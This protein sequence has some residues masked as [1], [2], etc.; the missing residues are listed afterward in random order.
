MNRFL[1]ALALYLLAATGAAAQTNV[2]WGANRGANPWTVCLYDANQVCQPVLTLPATGGAANNF[3]GV[4][5]GLTVTPTT[6][7]LTI[8]NGKTLTDTSGV[9]AKLLL[10]STGGGFTGY[11]GASSAGNVLT[12]IGAN[13][14]GSFQP[15]GT[16]GNSTLVETS[17]AGLVSPSILPF[18]TAANQVAQGGVI[19]AG[20]PIGSATVAPIITYNAAGQLTTVS[21]AT[22]TPAVGS[23]TGLGSNVGTALGNTLNA[24]GGLVGYSGALG[25]PTSGTL[26]NATGLPAA[27]GIA[28]GALPAGVTVNNGN[29]SGTGLALTNIATIA[30][31]SIV[32]NNTGSTGG[33]Y[34]LTGAQAAGVLN[35]TGQTLFAGSFSRTASAPCDLLS[36]GCASAWSVTRK[37]RAGYG[38]N[39]FQVTRASDNATQAIGI[40]SLGAVDTTTLVNFCLSTTCAVSII[41][42][43]AGSNNLTQATAANMPLV[44]IGDGQALPYVQTSTS[45]GTG[46]YSNVNTYMDNLSTSGLPTGAAAKTINIVQKGGYSACCGGFGLMENPVPSDGGAAE[47][48]QMF[49][50]VFLEQFGLWYF[51]ADVEQGY[52]YGAAVPALGNLYGTIKLDGSTGKVTALLNGATVA[53]AIWSPYPVNAGSRIALGSAGDKTPV[54]LSFYEGLIAAEFTSAA[55]DAAVY[56]NQVAFYNG[57][58]AGLPSQIAANC[59]MITCEVLSGGLTDVGTLWQNTSVG[60]HAW[61]TQSSGSGTGALGGVGGFTIR[62]TTSGAD[63]FAIKADGL[64][65]VGG[66]LKTNAWFTNVATT[67]DETACGKVVEFTGAGG[68]TL[69]IPSA[70]GLA[71]CTISLWSTGNNTTLS[72][73]SN[74]DGAWGTSSTSMTLTAGSTLDIKSDGYN[75]FTASSSMPLSTTASSASVGGLSSVQA[76]TGSGAVGGYGRFVVIYGSA[77]SVAL[78]TPVGSFGYVPHVIVWANTSSGTETLTTPSG[79][80]CG[81]AN[82]VCNSGSMTMTANTSHE[83][84]SDGINWIVVQ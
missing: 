60:G 70:S 39:L 47:P 45:G 58:T 9:G 5:E 61:L 11:G 76:I 2:I 69:T 57:G 56:Q 3:L 74:F 21:S 37:M 65:I 20:G 64:T 55:E 7:T 71:G 43:Q 49:A 35:F 63:W 82:P 16:T 6:G 26:T 54:M 75:W 8:A 38:G 80:F 22:I 52:A 84:V 24:S 18:G 46:P 34:A 42:D 31:N 23:I 15:Y 29:W 40:S 77:G 44:V 59:Y 79:Y 41:Y 36:S 14:A 73:V 78:P 13:G 12:A 25:T 50:T 48:G 53:N 30:A 72:S 51:G 4:F 28:N 17:S 19:T 67:F 81:P 83:F 33:P 66:G 10:G 32:G 62:D 27:T 1:A 68:L